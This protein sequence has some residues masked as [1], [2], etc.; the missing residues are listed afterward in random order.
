MKKNI[1]YLTVIQILRFLAPL[2]TFPYLTRVL[3]VES[4]GTLAYATGIII[5]LTLIV[6]F[7]FNKTSIIQVTKLKSEKNKLSQY[8]YTVIVSQLFLYFLS[9]LVIYTLYIMSSMSIQLFELIIVLSLTPLG[10]I[11][12]PNWLFI[13]LE[14]VKDLVPFT[15]SG[16]LISIPLTIYYVKGPQDILIAGL[17]QSSAFLISG[18][19]CIFYLFRRNFLLKPKIKINNIIQA[20][21]GSFFIFI[22]NFASNLYMAAVPIAIGIILGPIYVGYYKVADNIKSISLNLMSPIFNAVYARFNHL[23]NEKNTDSNLFLK[24]YFKISLSLSLCGSIILFIFSKLIIVII[25]GEEYLPGEIVLKIYAIVINISVFNQFFGTQTL[26]TLGYHK[27]FSLI[28]CIGGC[29]S[30]IFIYPLIKE[31]NITG[32]AVSVLTSEILIFLLLV[33]THKKNNINILT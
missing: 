14:K 16:R 25:A 28:V 29:F 24:K 1:F 10:L 15:L 9:I 7:G 8:I 13:G 2:I 21:K 4:F 31:F 30:V 18:L 19:I 11:F 22:T 3:G 26:I 27:I 6:E 17:I 32:A 33:Y 12:T 23:R 20:L 5:Y